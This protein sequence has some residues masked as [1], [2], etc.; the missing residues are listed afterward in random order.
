MLPFLDTGR[1]VS[2]SWASRTRPSR[3]LGN[4]QHDAKAR[5]SQV[6]TRGRRMAWKGFAGTERVLRAGPM[7]AALAIGLVMLL[8]GSSSFA[9]TEATIRFVNW[10]SSDQNEKPWVDDI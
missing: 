1:T 10:E 9:A 3:S 2:S 5:G 7:G 4:L 6:A 8:A